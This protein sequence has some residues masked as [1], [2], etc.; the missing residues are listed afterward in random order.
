MQHVEAGLV[1][2]KPGALFLHPAEG[3][4]GDAPVRLAVPRT[5]PVLQPHQFLRR[6]FD[7]H[8]DGILIRQPI[9]A[10]DGVVSV[11]VEAVVRPDGAGS[12]PFR[13]YRVTPHGV[14]LRNNRDS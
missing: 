14:H 4:H 8:F 12:S 11:L 9:T 13:G 7:K 1:G 3:S 6:F 10:G 2:G 5:A